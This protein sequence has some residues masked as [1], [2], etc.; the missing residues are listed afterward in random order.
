[1]KYVIFGAGSTLGQAIAIELLKNNH[2]V[3]GILHHDKDN[4]LVDIPY[5]TFCDVCN[6]DTMNN[7]SKIIKQIFGIPD[8]IIFCVG[9]SKYH[10]FINDKLNDWYDIFNVNF[11]GAVNTAYCSAQL[12]SKNTNGGSIILIGSGYGNRHIPYLSSYCVAK[13][14]MLSLVKTLSTE[15]ATQKIRINLVTPGIFPSN[16][17]KVFL[18]NHKYTSQLINHIPDREYGSADDLAK[19]IIFLTSNEARHINGAEIIVDGGMLNLIE[20]GIIR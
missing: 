6:I 4:S 8:H 2:Y 1:M 13:G 14:S 15:L 11:C 7:L 5:I 9:V 19:I 12:L 20:G 17:T 3:C 18:A 16:M 10:N